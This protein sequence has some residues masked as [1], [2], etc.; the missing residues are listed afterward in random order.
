VLPDGISSFPQ[1]AT[2]NVSHNKLQYIPF[3]INASTSSRSRSESFFSS[4]LDRAT[5]PLPALRILLA[6]HNQ[7]NMESFQL[8]HIP[9][10]IVE[11]DL[12]HNQLSPIGPLFSHLSALNHL[13][14]LRLNS[15]GLKS[16]FFP[17]NLSKLV[18]IKLLDLGENEELSEDTVRQALGEKEI[19]I[20]HANHQFTTGG[21]QVIFGKPAPA[22]EAWEVE[23]ENRVRL[24]KKSTNTATS[25]D[26]P[27]AIGNYDAP[28][29]PSPKRTP[30][31]T[32][33]VKTEEPVKE[34]WEIE[35]E[36]GLLTEGGRR[37]ARAAAVAAAAASPTLSTTKNVVDLSSPIA[38]SPP[39]S[40][41]N[42]V[43]LGSPPRG[44]SSAPSLVQFYDGPHATLTLP[45]SQPQARTHNRS[46]SVA[47]TPMS[48]NT[49][50][51]V[52]PQP[53]M[54]LPTILSQSFANSIKVLILSNRRLE[55]SIIL[56]SSRLSSPL[57]PHLDE[58][59]LDNCNLSSE[60]PTLI[61]GGS[62][63]PAKNSLLDII[64]ALFP[65]LSTLDLSYNLLT[66]LS[67]VGILM[68]PDPEKKRKGLTTLRL[69]GNRLSS[70]DPLEEL[71]A[72]WKSGG[73]IEG[74]RGEEIDL[75]DNEIG[76][77][78]GSKILVVHV[79]TVFNSYLLCLA[80]SRWTYCWWRATP[81]GF[82]PVEY[83]R[84]KVIA[85][86][87]QEDIN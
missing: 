67:G 62:A 60:V 20:G 27:F 2:L 17:A 79:L 75:R 48:T 29:V 13:Q 22:R 11:F 32:L 57:L 78:S 10:Q 85:H 87:I 36:Q 53:T 23:A 65:S 37:R 55:S 31:A 59:S 66:T 64:A 63:S 52:V 5:V 38:S 8:S 43:S 14:K 7:L 80:C 69:R 44:T 34:A 19:E 71:G 47:S 21:L 16:E 82:Q 81:F 46:F 18:A 28:P 15:C 74:W 41:M 30:T 9:R 73:G 72:T 70:L 76:K 39:V 33:K 4:T 61:D 40:E 24:R 83:G 86:P 25:A 54:P 1:L 26:N 77:V 68:T 51:L 84:E 45:R 56:P 49:S 35:A 12:S 50:D 58:L 3:Q 6:S 42:N